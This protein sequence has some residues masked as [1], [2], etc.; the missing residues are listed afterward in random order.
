MRIGNTDGGA[1]RLR[2]TPARAAP[3]ILSVPPGTRV[4]A[5]GSSERYEDLYWQLVRVPDPA[6]SGTVTEGWVA[7]DFLIPE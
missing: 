4:E 2:G 7:I 6:G 1:V 5:I 3:S